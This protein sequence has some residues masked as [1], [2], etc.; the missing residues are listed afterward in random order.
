MKRVWKPLDIAPG[1]RLYEV[2]EWYQ[3]HPGWN[4]IRVIAASSPSDAVEVWKRQHRDTKWVEE[5]VVTGHALNVC[6]PAEWREQDDFPRQNIS[7]FL[8]RVYDLL[9]AYRLK[10]GVDG[11]G[12]D[13]GYPKP[14]KWDAGKHYDAD[15]L[16]EKLEKELI[17]EFPELAALAAFNEPERDAETDQATPKE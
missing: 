4:Q 16:V 7:V 15:V 11:G 9:D 3:H 14:R 17:E 5:P 2:R 1:Y 10:R 8:T 12:S 6:Y 13:V